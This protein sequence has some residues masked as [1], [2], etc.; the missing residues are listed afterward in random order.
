LLK[1]K[2]GPINDLLV[3]NQADVIFTIGGGDSYC[4]KFGGTVSKNDQ[5]LF[6]AVK[7]P[8]ACSKRERVHGHLWQWHPERG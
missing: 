8:A 4:A 5:K 3:A 2:F 6:K 7:A 1:A